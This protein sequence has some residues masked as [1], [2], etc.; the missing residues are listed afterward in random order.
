MILVFHEVYL[1]SNIGTFKRYNTKIEQSLNLNDVK[2]IEK[3]DEIRH[4]TWIDDTQLEILITQTNG[5]IKTYNLATEN[6]KTLRTVELADKEVI[7]G[8]GIEP[9][10]HKLVTAT[11]KGVIKIWGKSSKEINTNGDLDRLRLCGNQCGTG[12]KENPLKIFDLET[13]KSTFVAK[14]IPNDK[15]ELRVPIWVSDLTFLTPTDIATS[16]RYDNVCL[17]DTRTQRRPITRLEYPDSAYG[18]I[19]T[20]Y[21]DKQIAIGGGKGLLQVIDLRNPGTILHKYKGA[22]GAITDVQCD[23]KLPYLFSCGYDRKLRIHDL[24]KPKLIAEVYLK[25][26]LNCLLVKQLEIKEEKNELDDLETIV[27]MDD[28][29]DSGKGK[30]KLVENILNVKKKKLK[31]VK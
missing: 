21:R 14:N 2:S 22:V 15:L 11:N 8:S 31:K 16:S 25:T 19:T 5:I 26:Q 30:R 3:G 6:F 20:T 24:L 1:G 9:K 12:G 7:I 10:N 27:E 4:L 18:C 23:P 28:V 13:L 29:E 17:Y